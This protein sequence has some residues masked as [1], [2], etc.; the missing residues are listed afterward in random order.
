[1][2]SLSAIHSETVKFAFCWQRN[3][4][5]RFVKGELKMSISVHLMRRVLLAALIMCLFGAIAFAQSTTDGAIG[6]TVYDST[7]AVVGGA[8]IVVHNN[9]TNAEQTTTAGSSGYYRV[10]GLEP[11]SYTVTST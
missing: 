4:N 3:T 1:M 6:G 10:S 2:R 7:G 8:K 5:S 11:V 9:G